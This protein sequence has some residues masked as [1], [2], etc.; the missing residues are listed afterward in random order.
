M[1]TT[2]RDFLQASTAASGGLL[3]VKPQ[4]AFGS[5]ANS[6]IELGL[7]G[8]G[9]RGNWIGKF[10]PEY[11]GA[12]IV[13]TA[14][15]VREHLDSTTAAFHVR[16]SRAYYG[17]DAYQELARSS[18]D[19]VIIETP[20]YYHPEHAQAA[21]DAGKHVFMAKPVAVDSPGCR[22]IL[23]SGQKAKGKKSFLVDFQTRAQSVFQEAAMRVHRGDLGR[24]VLGQAFYYAGRVG[25][26]RAT[27]DM[28]PEQTRMANQYCDQVLGGDIIVE[29]NVHVIDVAHWYLQSH[30]VK[31]FGTGG[32]TDWKGTT[33]DYGDAW[34]HFLVTFWY[35]G[36]AHVDFS[37]NQ[38]TGSF[39]DLCVRCFGV[40]GAVDS[41]YDGLVRIT[42][43]N[44]WT[45]TEKDPTFTQGAIANVKAFV[46]S[47]RTGTLLNNVETAVE[48]TQTAILGRMAAYQERVVTWDEVAQSS[49]KLEAHLKLRW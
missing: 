4:T 47:L 10:F 44:A 35:P 17:P 22:S 48:S 19:A 46:E 32:R 15:V 38:L 31:A 37:S 34:D 30:P 2:R 23:A 8:C 40:K 7:L 36:G 26:N 25:N 16:P 29:Q 5:Q 33:H 14:D 12:R 27:S 3:L 28:D 1:K 18:L 43:E 20:P 42:G 45:G 39:T 6:T 13:A 49:E 24:I 21:V 11:T 41:H 9:S